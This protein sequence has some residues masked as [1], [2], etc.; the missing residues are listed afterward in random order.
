[1][2]VGLA[3]LVMSKHRERHRPATMGLA[4]PPV[5]AHHQGLVALNGNV[6]DLVRA[7]DG[8]GGGREGCRIGVI[9]H[10]YLTG[11]VLRTVA[12]IGRTGDIGDLAVDES[13]AVLRCRPAYGA[14]ASE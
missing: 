11:A 4:L 6:Q 14:P 10:Q 7:G 2:T 13:D 9:Y 12:A 3:G 5:R 1:M 8:D